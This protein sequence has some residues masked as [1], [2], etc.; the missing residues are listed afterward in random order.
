MG[1]RTCVTGRTAID[2]Y[3]AGSLLAIAA[4]MAVQQAR[5]QTAPADAQAAATA[6][7]A[8]QT[9]P[10]QPAKATAPAAAPS[11]TVVVNLIRLLARLDSKTAHQRAVMLAGDARVPATLRISLL[12]CLGEVGRPECVRTLLHGIGSGE[13]EAVQLAALEALP[14]FS[15]EEIGIALLRHYPRLS[16][17]LRQRSRDV[18]LSRP[19]W[20]L[21]FLRAVDAK[22]IDGGVSRSRVLTI[23]HCR[24]PA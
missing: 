16:P 20:A 7:P 19:R 17:R 3:L 4:V 10:V 23:H 18:L 8:K 12:H 9:R 22:T 24:P 11:Q 15:G 21:A 6:K 2:R 1:K 5:A 14:R 13:P